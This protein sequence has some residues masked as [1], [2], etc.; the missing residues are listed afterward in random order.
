[1]THY[2]Y[3]H[4]FASGPNSQKA[5]RMALRFQRQGL[6]LEIPDLN[7]GDFC[8]LTLSRQ[9]DQVKQHILARSEP[10]VMIGSSLGG[11]T[12]AWATQHPQLQGRIRQLVL[13]APAFDFLPQWLPRLDPAQIDHWRASGYLGV[14]HYQARQTLPLHYDFWLDAATYCDR[15][16]RVP[17]PTLILHGLKDEVIAIE[18]SRAYAASRPWVSLIELDDD[19]S[20]LA[21]EALIWS[22]I[23]T[24]L[25]PPKPHST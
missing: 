19:H 1:M 25:Q 8:H 15:Q 4:G 3:L 22:H 2:L 20:L 21:T 16:L 12:A 24:F 14:Y 17:V 18:T 11:L 9:L 10:V 23:W 5:R 13:L 6:D 7:Q